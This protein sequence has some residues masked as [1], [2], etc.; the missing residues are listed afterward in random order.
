MD[1]LELHKKHIHGTEEKALVVEIT[2][3]L[4]NLTNAVI[5]GCSFETAKVYITSKCL[6]HLYDKKPAEEYHCLIKYL[7]QIVK[8]PDL[9]Y[10]NSAG[11]R[12]SLC[13]Y[14]KIGKNAYLCTLE[15]GVNLEESIEMDIANFIATCFRLRDENYLKKYKLLWS[16]KGDNPSS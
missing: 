13:F 12:G 11:K 16:W 5:K 9:I 1:I 7:P 4:C 14:K 15:K 2:I 8:H 10:Q 3:L 6:K